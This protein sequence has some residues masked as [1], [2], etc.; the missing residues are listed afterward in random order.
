[1]SR[2]HLRAVKA[3]VKATASES[4]GL[5]G[6]GFQPKFSRDVDFLGLWMTLVISSVL[7]QPAVPG[8]DSDSK[9]VRSMLWR[10]FWL[11]GVTWAFLFWC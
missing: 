9:V 5:S 4:D 2:R 7:G 6:A 10:G 8:S 1:M 3:Q 11:R